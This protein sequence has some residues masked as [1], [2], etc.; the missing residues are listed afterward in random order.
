MAESFNFF[1]LSRLLPEILDASKT[2]LAECLIQL[3]FC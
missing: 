1:I 3:S 2:Y